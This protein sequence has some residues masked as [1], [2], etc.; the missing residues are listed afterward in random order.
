M[1]YRCFAAIVSGLT[2]LA[3]CSE[4]QFDLVEPSVTPQLALSLD[5]GTR[6]F[7]GQ[8]ATCGTLAAGEAYCWSDSHPNRTFLGIGYD[9]AAFP[10]PLVRD[11]RFARMSV[12]GYHGCGLTANGTAWC[13][14]SNTY[15]QLG[16]GTKISRDYPKAVLTSK[17]FTAITVGT[18]VDRGFTCALTQGGAVYCWGSNGEGTLGINTAD[19]FK[20]V[21]TRIAKSA[22]DFVQVDA[23]N[24]YACALRAS[25]ALFCWG[26]NPTGELGLGFTSTKEIR[27][28]RASVPL[29]SA[30]SAGGGTTCGIAANGAGVFCW[31]SNQY[32]QTGKSPF[33][34]IQT[35]ASK[36][37]NSAGFTLVSVGFRHACALNG[38]GSAF[39]WGDNTNG[40]LGTG[41]GTKLPTPT[42]VYGGNVF[43]G[44]GA[45]AFGG[46]AWRLNGSAVCWGESDLGNGTFGGS[47]IPVEVLSP[48]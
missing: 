18:Q 31:G 39:C 46:C 5:I 48:F 36:V 35:A 33:T 1:N 30:V 10:M 45:S 8:S 17:K 42:P 19:P 15:G 20:L 21:P 3:G 37:A 2:V 38:T 22:N 16:D 41:V 29:L 40:Q 9:R 7:V 47:P 43:E 14:G 32:G 27:P 23:G 44:L 4:T 26:T 6:L 24:R 34:V 13:W 28:L 11:L 12:S 25:G